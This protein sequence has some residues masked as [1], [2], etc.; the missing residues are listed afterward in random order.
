[1]QD[2]DTRIII[3]S[4]SDEIAPKIF[5][6]VSGTEKFMIKIR[7]K[8]VEAS[9]LHLSGRLAMNLNYSFNLIKAYKL[10]MYGADYAWILQET[11]ENQRWWDRAENSECSLKS[12]HTAVESVLIVSSYNNIVGEEKSISGLVCDKKGEKASQRKGLHK[13]KNLSPSSFQTN[14]LFEQE[15]SS[16]NVSK[17]FSRFAPE[18]Y[19]AVWSIALA[20]R[21]AEEMWRNDSRQNRKRKRKKLELFDY[22]RKDLAKDFLE[23]FSR[24]KFQGISVSRKTKSLI[25]FKSFFFLFVFHREMFHSME[26]TVSA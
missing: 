3:G 22:T 21:G 6:E 20:L 14:S 1:M 19:D 13:H 12:L 26:L 23:Q 11:F 8:G 4:F 24:L 9:L 5:C 18:T 10:G 7:S 15:L 17:P 25:L 2:L 16:M